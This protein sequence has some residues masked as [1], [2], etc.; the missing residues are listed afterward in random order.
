MATANG[1]DTD[2]RLRDLNRKARRD[3]LRI[4][5]E[6]VESEAKLV[7]QESVTRSPDAQTSE[8]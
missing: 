5:R 8:Q 2:K 4:I 1:A 7:S 3:L 6:D